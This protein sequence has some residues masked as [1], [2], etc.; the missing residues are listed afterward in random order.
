MGSNKEIVDEVIKTIFYSDSEMKKL[1][2]VTTIRNSKYVYGK[3]VQ[4]KKCARCKII[5]VISRTQQYE[6]H[7][8]QLAKAMEIINTLERN[9][10]FPQ[11]S[12]YCSF[13]CYKKA[14]INYLKDSNN[15]LKIL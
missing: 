15:L 10:D 1:F 5:F 2:R 7:K 13:S 8:E 4:G 11:N 3:S 6:K 14:V 9:S 12:G